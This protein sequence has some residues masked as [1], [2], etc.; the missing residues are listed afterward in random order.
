V[1]QT[2]VVTASAL[3][4][5]RAPSTAE[6]RIGSLSRG[7]A[8]SIVR[9]QGEWHEIEKPQH[10]WVASRYI[11]LDPAPQT[12][13]TQAPVT[14]EPFDGPLSERPKNRKEVIKM[15]GDPT[16]GGLYKKVVDPTWR[17]RD[18]V[19]LHGSDAFLP[20]LAKSYFPIHHDIEP[21]A[22]EAFVRAERA[23]PGYIHRAGT[24]GYNFRHMRHILT[25]PLS[26]HSWGIAIDVNPDDNGA[27][28]FAKG[29]TPSPWS[30]EWRQRWPRGVPE[31]V[32]RA[33]ESC[34]FA[35]GGRWKGYCDPMH[36]EWL[37][38]TPT[39]V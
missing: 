28:T 27:H 5:R 34:G 36:F 4:L 38:Q 13:P 1:S 20:V 16:R 39:Q 7:T 37:G 29:K 2:G 18:I 10:G 6:P 11:A 23:V 32:V 22:R 19:E 25:M 9:T 24:W 35:W 15:F 30:A 12:D 31:G 17:S 3:N 26:Y 14:F 21:Y 33:F 8:V